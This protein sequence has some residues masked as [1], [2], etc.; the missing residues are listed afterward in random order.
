MSEDERNMEQEENQES[1][2]ST[3]TN[4][5]SDQGFWREMW[6]QIRLAWYLFRSPEVPMYLKVLPALAIVYVLFPWDFIPDV[7]PVIGQ[8]DD[9]TALIVGAKVF[10]ELAPQDVVNRRIRSMRPQAPAGG[11]EGTGNGQTDELS[12]DSIVIEGEFQ[13]VE[14]GNENRAD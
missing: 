11:N 1:M 4:N 5:L 2:D 10:I 3:L 9:L 12:D 14:D 6:H 13:I 7:L 8:L